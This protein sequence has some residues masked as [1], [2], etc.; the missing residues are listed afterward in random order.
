MGKVQGKHHECAV[1]N[2]DDFIEIQIFFI[3]NTHIENKE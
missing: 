2:M 3:S 1:K